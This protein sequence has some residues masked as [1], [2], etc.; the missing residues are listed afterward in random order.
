MSKKHKKHDHEEHIDETWLI[1]YADLL[2]L[3]LALFIV[4]FASSQID[5]KKFDEMS[6]AF[7]VALN[8]GSGVLDM[9]TIISEGESQKREKS[10]DGEDDSKK[11]SS[12]QQPDQQSEIIKETHELEKLKQKLDKY[13]KENGLTTQ[14]DTKLNLTELMILSL[15]HI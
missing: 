15:I 12:P 9:P 13:I 8:A 2:T 10:D 3:L 11:D 7:S 5:S 1:P 4:L 6:R 14:L